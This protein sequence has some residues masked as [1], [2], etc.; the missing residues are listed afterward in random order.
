MHISISLNQLK[1]ITTLLKSQLMDILLKK[2]FF[3]KKN[4]KI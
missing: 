1:Q 3:V 4:G 2:M